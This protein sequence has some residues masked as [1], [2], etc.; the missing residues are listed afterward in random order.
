M[1]VFDLGG[2]VVRKCVYE[3][4]WVPQARVEGP[5]FCFACVCV[6]FGLGFSL[7]ALFDMVNVCALSLSLG[8]KPNFFRPAGLCRRCR[9][10]WDQLLNNPLDQP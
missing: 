5:G 1:C 7:L 4:S 9:S 3:T 6:W 8:Y 10:Q 2:A